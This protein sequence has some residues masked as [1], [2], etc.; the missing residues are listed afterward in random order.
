MLPGCLDRTLFWTTADL[1]T[2]LLDFKTYFAYRT[3]GPTTRGRTAAAY[4]EALIVPM[5]ISLPRPVSNTDSR[6]ISQ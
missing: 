5:G 2:K 6:L 1:E 4:R 3:L